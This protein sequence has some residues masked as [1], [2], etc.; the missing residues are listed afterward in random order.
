MIESTVVAKA[1]HWRRATVSIKPNALSHNLNKVRQYA[2]NSQIMA[3]IKA[4]AYGHGLLSV[5]QQLDDADMFAVAMPE[6][7]Y[8]L[9]AGGCSKPIL[10]L[11]GFYDAMELE[12]FSKLQLSTVVHQHRQLDL[13]LK[14]KLLSVIDAWIKVDTGMHRLGILPDELDHYFGQCRNAKNVNNVFVMSHFANA[15]DVGNI[16]NNNQ[17]NNFINVTNDI[18]VS[19]SMANS[20]AIMRLPK[21]HFEIVRPGIMLYGSSPFSDVSATDL[22][23]QAVMQFESILIEIKK[24]KAG[25]SIGYG[26]TFTADKELTM[27]VVAAGYG[28]GY[29]RHAKNGTPVW[30]NNQRSALLGR[31]SMDS[32]CID[33]TDVGASIGDRVVLW[34]EELSVDEVAQ[35]SDTIAY[36][37]L[38]HA[39][40]AVNSE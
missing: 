4:N 12:Q 34:G 19:C 26:S 8:A 10:V 31:V 15:D 22:G 38:C 9:R 25:G 11:H 6:E 16:L 18:D 1:G 20:A 21:S 28:D 37:L 2:P 27:G 32:L 3:V 5:A 17:L 33:L 30:I 36:E 13:L 40:K 23:L 39:G 24:V 14:Q 35:F 7:A 29:P